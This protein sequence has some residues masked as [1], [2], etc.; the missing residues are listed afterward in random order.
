MKFAGAVTI[1]FINGRCRRVL[2]NDGDVFA[3]PFAAEVATVLADD[4]RRNLRV[5][6]FFFI[7]CWFFQC[8]RA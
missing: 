3:K 4:S 8:L 6:A 1:E 2:L 7:I 5:E